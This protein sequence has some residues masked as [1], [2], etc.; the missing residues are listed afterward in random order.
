MITNASITLYNHHYNKETR[1][2]DWHRTVIHGVH[3]YADNKVALGDS[4]LSTA[5]VYKIRVPEDAEC[6]KEYVPEDEYV[7]TDNGD[8]CWTLQ[9]GDYIVCGE[10]FL[11]I[12]KPADLK[13]LHK[14]YC[15]ITSWSDNRF[16][17]LPH[18]R[19]GGV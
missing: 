15:K 1:L 10:C 11:N 8:Y 18:W 4:T 17:G 9:N 7:H 16:G 13:Q 3:F 12:E 19:I 5:D 6:D 2:D 14:Q